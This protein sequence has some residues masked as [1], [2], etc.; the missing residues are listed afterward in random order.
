MT[1]TNSPNRECLPRH[2]AMRMA[3]IREISEIRVR[4]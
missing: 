4:K 2:A 1:N 3:V